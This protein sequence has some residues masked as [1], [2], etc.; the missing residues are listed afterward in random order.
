M[1]GLD[2]AQVAG[3][4]VKINTVALKGINDGEAVD[5]VRWAHGR[6]FDITFIELMPLGEDFGSKPDAFL[7]LRDL[8]NDLSAAFR[9]TPSGD[10]TG[11][12]ARYDRVTETG[13]RI[14]FITPLTHNFCESCNRVRVTCTGTLFMCLGQN[15]AVDLREPMRSS[16]NDDALNAAIDEAISKKPK[17][18]DFVAD[19]SMAK[20][21]VGRTMSVTGG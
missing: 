17:G 10:R 20:P 18:H 21:R 15:D 1:N 9:L 14:G 4:A 19:R 12:P 16:A 7:S 3:L 2:A 13:G 5:M 11:G 6:G 8:R